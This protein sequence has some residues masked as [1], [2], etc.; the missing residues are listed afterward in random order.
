MCIVVMAIFHNAFFL[1][2]QQ[3][4]RCM[5]FP[6]FKLACVC[7]C[8]R[9]NVHGA[10]LL[11]CTHSSCLSVLVVFFVDMVDEEPLFPCFCCRFLSPPPLPYPGFPA[12]CVRVS[13]ARIHRLC[14]KLYHLSTRADT[15]NLLIVF[16]CLCVCVCV[17]W[18]PL[19][20]ML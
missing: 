16:D 12:P 19:P 7:V 8:L 13:C 9:G 14:S 5:K 2:S 18:V 20:Q 17:Y 6:F 15:V 4:C 1:P 10:A 3:M 11:S